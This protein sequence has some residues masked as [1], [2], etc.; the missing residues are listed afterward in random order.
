MDAAVGV[1]LLK[2]ADRKSTACTLSRAFCPPSLSHADS[3]DAGALPNDVH[4][5]RSEMPYAM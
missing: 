5:L 1:T 4:V 2:D 3:H